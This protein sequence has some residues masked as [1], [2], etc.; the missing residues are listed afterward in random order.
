MKLRL[1]LVLFLI[2]FFAYAQETEE[3]TPIYVGF[4]ADF[5]RPAYPPYLYG[6]QV[7]KHEGNVIYT[8][9]T[10]GATIMCD[11]AYQYYPSDTIEFFGKVIVQHESTILFSDKIFY[12][13]IFAKVRGQLVE[14]HDSERKAK[15]RTQF[16]DY[17]ID[18][19]IGTYSQGGTLAR[20]RDT[21]ESIN[22]IFDGNTGVFTFINS[23]AMKNDSILLVCD[24]MLYD[25]HNDVTTFIGN[26]K[27][28]NKD[29][30][31][32]SDFGLY[33]P[34]ENSMFFSGNAYI[35]ST[36]QEVWA[37]SIYFDRTT[38][39]GNLFGNIQMLDTTQNML[40]FGDK[41]EIREKMESI[42]VTK[43]PAALHYTLPKDETQ[44]SDTTYLVADTIS[45]FPEKSQIKT[46]C[47]TCK[48]IIPK[49]TISN[50]TESVLQEG[51]IGQAREFKNISRNQGTAINTEGILQDSA[52]EQ[53]KEIEDVVVQ[54]V[55]IQETESVSQEKIQSAELENIATQQN[56][57]VQDTVANTPQ[58]EIIT[59]K[60]LEL[61]NI[62]P[63]Q[64]TPKRI[65]NRLDITEQNK[66][67]TKQQTP[68]QDTTS[69]VIL[70]R[71]TI[72]RS[73]FAYQNVKV[74]KS[75]F[76]ALCDSLVY[77]SLDS[78]TY[79]YH[80]PILWNDSMQVTSG[81]STFYSKNQQMDYAEFSSPALIVIDR[82]STRLNSSH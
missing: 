69:Q 35:E 33:K 30:F 63:R 68:T 71:D 76:Q 6:R 12:D 13:G 38:Q 54:D 3:S 79:M 29:N 19:N 48:K 15:L 32:L 57:S 74:F 22:G 81:P 8:H 36:A 25:T 21:I 26:T 75:D 9:K 40:I 61:G 11:S 49:D 50:N 64:N 66:N 52:T 20:E 23:V 51:S 47:D 41:A 45:S 82:K 37:D 31:M 59:E 34:N 42:T 56:I 78:I 16:I 39:D 4:Q 62:A 53:T 58:E 18:R 65:N 27:S 28:W 44:I 67:T 80:S 24:T 7:H 43:N 14:M 72:T 60:P 77:H 70:T 73:V 1:S 17:N 46:I 55:L 10:N 2:S 5:M